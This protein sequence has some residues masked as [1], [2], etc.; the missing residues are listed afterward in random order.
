[1]VLKFLFAESGYSDLLARFADR[2]KAHDVLQCP[3]GKPDR[4]C[5][6]LEFKRG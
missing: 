6:H 5:T 1:L 3:S 2:G 4:A